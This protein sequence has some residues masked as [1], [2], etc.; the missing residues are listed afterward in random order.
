MTAAK[1]GATLT[2]RILGS[3]SSPGNPRI[4]GDWGRC[5]PTNPKNRRRR[6]SLLVTRTS[7]EGSKTRVLVDTGPD[8]RDQMLDAAVDW[9]DGV[10]YTHAHA[11]HLHGIDDLRAF[12]LNRRQ[13]VDVWMDEVTSKRIH[14]AFGYCFVTPPGSAY[15]PI[16]KEHRLSVGHPAAIRGEG[17][18][19]T[20]LPFRQVHGDIDTLGLRFGDVAYSTDVSAIPDESLPHLQKLDLWIIDALRWK[21]HPSHFSVDESLGWIARKQPKHAVLT[22]L[23]ND[24][25]Y[26]VLADYVPEGVE[27]A[28]DGMEITLP[29]T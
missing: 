6:A 19:I 8:L 18:T 5:D 16:L 1:R 4:G 9:I 21:S 23:H 13:L 27:P 17:G 7:P 10:V 28:Y 24:V 20:V 25:D 22:H 14:Q 12:V 3:G 15:P 29:V 2:F 26:R 11:D